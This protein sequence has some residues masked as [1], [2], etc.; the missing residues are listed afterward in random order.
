[1]KPQLKKHRGQNHWYLVYEKQ[2]SEGIIQRKSMDF[3]T[4]EAGFRFLTSAYRILFTAPT[5]RR[6]IH[7]RGN[8]YQLRIV[9][10]SVFV[11]TDR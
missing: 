4:Q 7:V 2:S 11:H 3:P 5:G 1:M 8:L 10:K 6:T 9:P